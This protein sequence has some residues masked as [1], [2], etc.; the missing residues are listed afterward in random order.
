MELTK[1]HRFMLEELMR[2]QSHLKKE[3]LV[4]QRKQI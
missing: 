4:S 3:I 2:T 1:T